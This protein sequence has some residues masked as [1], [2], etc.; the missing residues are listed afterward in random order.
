M[1]ARILPVMERVQFSVVSSLGSHASSSCL[2][3]C[4]WLSRIRG[5][6]RERLVRWEMV[7]ITDALI[8]CLQGTL[9]ECFGGFLVGYQWSAK[10]VE[11]CSD[12]TAVVELDGAASSPLPVGSS[13]LLC[14]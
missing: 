4:Y 14:V 2:L 7:S 9:S 6:F 1:V 3:R 11:F 5:Y 12:T 8:R 13:A 10:R